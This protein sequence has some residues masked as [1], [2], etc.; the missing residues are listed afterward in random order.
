MSTAVGI[1]S[2]DGL[3]SGSVEPAGTRH[4][5]VIGAGL[6]GLAAA[7]R[8]RRRGYGSPWWNG[9]ATPADAAASGS[10]RASDSIPDPRLL[11]M[12]EY[13]QRRF[14]GGRPGDG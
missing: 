11:L 10:R 3:I 13:L 4:V 14:R 12:V 7:V 2:A 5:L 6:G 9:M 8:L 1:G